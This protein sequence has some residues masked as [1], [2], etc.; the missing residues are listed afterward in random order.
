MTEELLTSRQV[1]EHTN[2][3]LKVATLNYWRHANDGTGP[4]W[5]RL[6]ARK[7][8]YK[9]SDLEAWLEEQYTKAMSEQAAAVR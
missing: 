8:V 9:K 5:F 3:A 7:V 1:E 2:G 6:G 4:R